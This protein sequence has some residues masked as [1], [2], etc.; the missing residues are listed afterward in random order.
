MNKL[1]IGVVVLAIAAVAVSYVAGCESKRKEIKDLRSVIEAKDTEA[2]IFRD[3]SNQW[4]YRA[5]SAEVKTK[6]AL[7]YL[8]Q[9]DAD[10]SKIHNEI[11]SVKKDLSNL[12]QYTKTA[13][14]S[15]VKY[16]VPGNDTMFIINKDTISGKSYPF[17]NGWYKVSSVIHSGKMHCEI[18]SVDTTVSTIT[19]QRKWFLGKKK[20]EIEQ[21]NKNPYTKIV[22]VK[23]LTVT[24][25]RK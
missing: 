4:R 24:K 10:F 8:A 11:S 21:F 14:E 9:Y 6:E 16:S 7:R 12:H 25:K 1:F 22:Y 19:F 3:E 17:N 2:K 13:T 5:V 15:G 18:S 20:Y 23:S